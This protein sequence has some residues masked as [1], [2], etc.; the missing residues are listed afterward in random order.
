MR[1]PQARAR[2]FAPACRW[3]PAVARSAFAPPWRWAPTVARSAFAASL[4]AVA[5]LASPGCGEG[6]KPPEPPPCD[7][8]CQDSTALRSLRETVKLAFNLT[9][10]G[11]PVGLQDVTVPCVLGGNVRVVG[12]ANSN[13]I[14]GATEVRLTYVFAGC[15]YIQKDSESPENYAMT[16]N[17][18]LTQ[19]GVLA[20]QPTATTALRMASDAMTFSG[21]VYDPPL[22]YEQPDCPLV[23]AQ[24]GSALSGLICGREAGYD[25]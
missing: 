1:H 9:V 24:N 3:A 6:S 20:V 25:L 18:T 21:S 15:T 8:R 7:Q 19:E 14:Q 16:F 11:K 2:V 22:P 23:I 13:P 12:E 17:G 5:A 4:F 10:Q